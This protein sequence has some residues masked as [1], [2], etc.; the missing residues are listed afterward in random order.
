VPEELLTTYSSFT[1]ILM[2]T[3]HW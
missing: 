1:R 3:W 2:V